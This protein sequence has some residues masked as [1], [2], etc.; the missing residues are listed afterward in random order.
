MSRTLSSPSPKEQ[1]HQKSLRDAVA[2]D[3]RNVALSERLYE[4]GQ[5]NLLTVLIGVQA[6]IFRRVG[7][8]VYGQTSAN[9]PCF[10]NRPAIPS[11]SAAVAGSLSN[12]YPRE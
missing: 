1:K 9:W 10:L 11:T 5:N 7:G 6:F 8:P 4:E 3:G 2:A 12:V